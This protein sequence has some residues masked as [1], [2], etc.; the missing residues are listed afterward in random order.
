MHF[1]E[2]KLLYF[3]SN[4]TEICSQV[5]NWQYVCVG[6]GNGLAPNRRQAN[7]WTNAGPVYWRIYAVLG[8]DELMKINRRWN[9][10]SNLSQWNRLFIYRQWFLVC[11][12]TVGVLRRNLG[13]WG[14]IGSWY[15]SGSNKRVYIDGVCYNLLISIVKKKKKT[16]HVVG[17]YVMTK[18]RRMITYNKCRRIIILNRCPQSRLVLVTVCC[19][20]PRIL[21]Y[22]YRN[23]KM[24]V[25]W[26]NTSS[27]FFDVTNGVKQWLALS[28]SLFSMHVDDLITILEKNGW[29]CLVGNQFYGIMIYADDMFLL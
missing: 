29:G 15:L 3:D 20:W 24:R 7:I 6:S 12:E 26:G 4:F 2:W 16:A 23:S 18:Q 5:S 25:R 1:H 27:N 22:M 19:S 8:G 9:L 10:L 21:T 14:W 13:E 11:F 28:P 17:K